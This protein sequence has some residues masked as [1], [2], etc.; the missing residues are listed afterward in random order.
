MSLIRTP[1]TDR[2]GRQTH[3][4]KR[5]TADIPAKRDIPNEPKTDFAKQAE[6]VDS[7]VL[8][9]VIKETIE[10]SPLSLDRVMPVLEE[11]EAKYGTPKIGRTRAVFEMGDGRVLKIAIN[12]EGFYSNYLELRESE[13]EDAY[14]PMAKTERLD[15]DDYNSAVIAEQVTPVAPDYKTMP[16]WV[17]SVDGGQVGYTSDGRLVAYDL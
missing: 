10:D 4:W 11:L 12:D 1:I 3:V 16:E 8:W 7:E 14:V 2:N 9:Q 5:S 15:I 17:Y 13:A 6:S